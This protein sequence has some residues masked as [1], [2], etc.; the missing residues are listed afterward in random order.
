M[1]D[2]LKFTDTMRNGT[3]GELSGGWQIK[4]QL[5]KAVLVDADILLLDEPTNHLDAATV[6]WL[7]DCLNAL[8]HTTVVTVSHDT[9]FVKNTCTDVIHYKKLP[10]EWGTDYCK[11]VQ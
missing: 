5:A 10:Q 4:L 3:I 7:V 2:T 11:L 1:L 8:E 9:Q 6:Q